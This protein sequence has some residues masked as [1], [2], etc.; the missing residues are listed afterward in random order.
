MENTEMQPLS[1]GLTKCPM[2][3]IPRR[4]RVLAGLH[5]AAPLL[6]EKYGVM[7]LGVFGSVARD[8]A[9]A[10]SDIDI[11]LELAVPDLF[12]MVEIKEDLEEMFQRRIDVI[13]YRERMNP[14]LKR[15]IERDAIY[16]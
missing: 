5:Q 9:T 16:V 11:V 10:A 8:E 14:Y 12:T 2:V 4:D 13:R 7:R 6:A 3:E 15:R 1:S